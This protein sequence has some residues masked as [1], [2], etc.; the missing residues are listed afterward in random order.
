[1]HQHLFPGRVWFSRTDLREQHRFVPD[2][3]KVRPNM[4]HG[5]VVLGPQQ[6]AGRVWLAPATIKSITE[7]NEVGTR[8]TFW[9]AAADGSTAADSFHE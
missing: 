4:P 3:F 1:V 2:F 7:F 8:L 5:A 6:A 9:R